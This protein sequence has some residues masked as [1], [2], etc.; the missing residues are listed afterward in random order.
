M[1]LSS[2]TRQ[3]K[4]D[5]IVSRLC[6]SPV[7]RFA[8]LEWIGSAVIS[9]TQA[10]SSIPALTP[11]SPVPTPFQSSPDHVHTTF[12]HLHNLDHPH[13]DH[14]SPQSDV[15]CPFCFIGIKQVEGAIKKYNQTHIPAIDPIIRFLPFKL[16]NETTESPI[17]ISEAVARKFGPERV[18]GLTNAMRERFRGMGY[19][20]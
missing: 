10:R 3:L 18:E 19:E 2:T 1:A 13:P 15:I 6:L 8:S 17:P 12:N 11:A 4:I 5:I 16:S 20:M 9:P 7:L 14:S